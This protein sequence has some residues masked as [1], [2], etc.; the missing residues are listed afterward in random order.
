MEPESH[1]VRLLQL[2]RGVIERIAQR[3]I[4]ILA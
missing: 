3:K 2:S 1:A 4:D